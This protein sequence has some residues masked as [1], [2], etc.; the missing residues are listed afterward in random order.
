MSAAKVNLWLAG[1][2]F[3]LGLALVTQLKLTSNLERR[4]ASQ[5]VNDLVEIINKLDTE[6]HYLEQ[7]IEKNQ[8]DL[9][10]YVKLAADNSALVENIN[11]QLVSLKLL[12]GQNSVS[13]RGVKIVIQDKEHLLTGFDLQQ[14]IYEIKAADGWAVAVNGWRLKQNSAFWR[15]KGKVYLDGKALKTPYVIEAKGRKSALIFQALTLPRGILDRLS[16]VRG[17]SIKIKQTKVYLQ[18]AKQ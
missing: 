2:L 14:I 4:L 3:L 8:Q 13:G 6:N 5:S 10:Q 9:R 1:L 12:L 16:T 11:K 7:Q 18:P 17:V 15:H